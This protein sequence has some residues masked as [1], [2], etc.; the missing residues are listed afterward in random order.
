VSA[1]DSVIFL[2][3]Y[4]FSEMLHVHVGSFT[5]FG[6]SYMPDSGGYQHQGRFPVGEV[7]YDLCPS[8]YVPGYMSRLLEM[9][10]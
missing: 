7:A 5:P 9:V 1:Y 2:L 8:H 4:L 6:G 3:Q 10:E